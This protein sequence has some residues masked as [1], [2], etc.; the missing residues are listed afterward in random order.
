LKPHYQEVITLHYG[1]EKTFADIAALKNTTTDAVIKT[2]KRALRA[3]RR[4]IEEMG[5]KGW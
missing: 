4:T 3:W 5:F 1:A 2:W